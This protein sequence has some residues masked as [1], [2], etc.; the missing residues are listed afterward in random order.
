MF[1]FRRVPEYLI[2]ACTVEMNGTFAR[3]LLVGLVEYAQKGVRTGTALQTLP[4]P[5][6]AYDLIEKIYL[7]SQESSHPRKGEQRELSRYAHID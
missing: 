6:D 5:P 4:K 2:T 1:V 3:N 7:Q